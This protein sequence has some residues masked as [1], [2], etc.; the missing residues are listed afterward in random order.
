MINSIKYD[1]KFYRI[2]ILAAL[3]KMAFIKES[4]AL[5]SIDLYPWFVIVIEAIQAE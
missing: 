5:S 4:G 1:P 2:D 3:I